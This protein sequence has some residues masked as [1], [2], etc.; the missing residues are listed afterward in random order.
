M[1]K[2]LLADDDELLLKTYRTMFERAGYQV[3]EAQ[4]GEEAEHKVQTEKPDLVVLD[5]AMPK[6]DGLMVMKSLRSDDSTK[7]IPIIIL[8]AKD[9]D[10]ERTEHIAQWSPTFYLVKGSTSLAEIVAK[11]QQVLD[12]ENT[13][14]Y[15]AK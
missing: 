11:A 5:V 4:D 13:Q 12:T 6:K 1:K 3:C 10:D 14:D 15:L 2:I 9:M 8:T 7:D